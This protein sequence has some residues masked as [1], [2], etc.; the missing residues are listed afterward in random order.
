MVAAALVLAAVMAYLFRY[1]EVYKSST[2][3]AVL[4]NSDFSEQVI[5]HFKR[6][7]SIITFNPEFQH[8]SL[9]LSPDAE[10][11]GIAAVLKK[12]DAER[13][14]LLTIVTGGKGTLQKCIEG[15]Y[16][17]AF[18]SLCKA[19]PR[20]RGTVYLRWNPEMEVP[21]ERYAW[22]YQAPGDYI[23]A[24]RH[25][26]GVCRQGAPAARI[27][28]GTAGYPGADEY[29][30]G[31]DVVD[32]VGISV[33]G[34]SERTATAYPPDPDLDV[35]LRRKLIRTR[36]ADKPVMMLVAG[37]DSI[38]SSVQKR[39]GPVWSVIKTESAI[40]FQPF[41]DLGE[42]PVNA[43]PPLVGVYDPKQLLTASPSVDVEHLFVDLVSIQNGEFEK[44]FEGVLTRGNRPVITVEPW[45]DGKVRTDSSVLLNTINNVYDGEFREVFRV[46]AKAQLPV[47]VRF[48]HEMEI[49]IHRYSWQSQDPVLYI[50][51]YR[52][53]MEL[54][55]QIKN[56]RMVWGPAGDRGSMEW[57]P[58]DDMVDFVSIAIYGLPDKNITDPEKQ[59]SFESIYNRKAWR[60]RL[61]SKPIFITEF[62]VKGPEAY[63][64][65]WMENAARVVARHKEIA[66]TCYFNLADNPKVWGDIPAPDWS[67]SRA[68]FDH[69]IHTFNAN[70]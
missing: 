34:S 45:R 39:L 35:A 69:F 26:A 64:R 14:W 61:T 11:Q 5:A 33:N 47:Y 29:W 15:K 53:F 28:W 3:P 2:E 19:L 20:G 57:Y 56:V 4:I 18:S 55:K 9:K 40:V 70:R 21:V 10:E 65:K 38:A 6:S 54:G 42:L 30:P 46:A 23:N 8:L 62:G 36:F 50:K 22:Q 68:T 66:G 16:D 59:E 60:M 37:G 44:E 13:D 48:A 7:D 41:S 43:E 51:A 67:I 49:P 24:F 52:H 27:V 17:D 12:I 25:M 63:Q 32:V 1:T 58:G 31:K